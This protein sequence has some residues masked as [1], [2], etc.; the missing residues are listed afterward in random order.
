[1]KDLTDLIKVVTPE[2]LTHVSLFTPKIKSSTKLSQLYR[3]ILS[4]KITTNEDAIT[5]LYKND[6]EG[7]YK[8]A[9]LKYALKSKLFNNILLLSIDR[10]ENP[11]K[12]ILFNS[13]RTLLIAKFLMIQGARR[14]SIHILEQLLPSALKQDFTV[15]ALESSKLLRQYYTIYKYDSEQVKY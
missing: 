5:Q 2:S 11:R 12:A 6:E 15:Q 8:L 4:G 3:K 9:K 1:M 14:L 7:S 10:R 13:S